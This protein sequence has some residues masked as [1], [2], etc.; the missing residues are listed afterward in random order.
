MRRIFRLSSSSL[1]SW[2]AVFSCPRPRFKKEEKEK[3]SASYF[4]ARTHAYRKDF[5]KKRKRCC[6]ARKVS[7]CK[8][9]ASPSS[10]EADEASASVMSAKE[11]TTTLISS[12][13]TA[14]PPPIPPVKVKRS[15]SWRRF[16]ETVK[17]KVQ[18]REET[19][20]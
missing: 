4:P 6:S 18:V 9:E 15:G 20:A 13:S 7:E 2:P 16:K 1:L 10:N 5:L 19:S 12:P 8:M 14:N 3:R 17:E 11:T